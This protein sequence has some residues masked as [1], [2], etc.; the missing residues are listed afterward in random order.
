MTLTSVALIEVWFV[1]SGNVIK[2]YVAGH[3]HFSV[4]YQFTS[5]C[6]PSC[7]RDMYNMPKPPIRPEREPTVHVSS[8]QARSSE[9]LLFSID[10]EIAIILAVNLGR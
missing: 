4:H 1:G 7:P 2:A 6:E 3:L 10:K 8:P 9:G 5:L